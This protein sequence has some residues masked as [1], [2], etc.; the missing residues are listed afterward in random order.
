MTSGKYTDPR[1]HLPTFFLNAPNPQIPS[2]P[3]TL[4]LF[5]LCWPLMYTYFPAHNILTIRAR[6]V[7]FSVVFRRGHPRAN[8]NIF[9][10]DVLFYIHNT[11]Q[12]RKFRI[13]GYAGS[14]WIR[15]ASI[16]QTS[17]IETSS[18]VHASAEIIFRDDGNNPCP[19][20][21]HILPKISISSHK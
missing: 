11:K 20:L 18:F 7:R 2:S 1:C 4:S 17:M 16:L 21:L 8:N 9:F 5:L 14:G 6:I 10:L 15:R 13:P 19:Y 12:F 3:Q